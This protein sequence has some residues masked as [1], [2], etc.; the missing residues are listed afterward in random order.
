GYG[1]ITH[2]QTMDLRSSGFK[3]AAVG[4][5]SQAS[6]DSFA[7]EFGIATAHGSYEALVA[8][9]GVD[10]I[11]VSTPHPCHAPA[12]KLALEAGKHVLLEKPFTVNAREARQVVELAA[13]RGLVVLEAMW[14]RFLPQSVRVRELIAD[15]VIGE[16]R[17][18]IAD[19][20]Q[21]LST[22]P[23]HRINNLA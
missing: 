4:S 18:L 19:H 23:E 12:A 11:Y 17:T 10:A 15:G 8:D 21:L 22:D 5:R 14:T 1:G 9:P 13:E 6:A 2:H 20:N 3:V 16:P 7:P